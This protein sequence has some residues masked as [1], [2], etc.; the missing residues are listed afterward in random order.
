MSENRTIRS[1]SMQLLRHTVLRNVQRSFPQLIYPVK[2]NIYVNLQF[3]DPETIYCSSTATH[4]AADDIN[5][6]YYNANTS[7]FTNYY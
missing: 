2:R 5:N 7:R 6:L 1:S 3:Q 4:A